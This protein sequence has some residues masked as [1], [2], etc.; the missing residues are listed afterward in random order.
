MRR[1]ALAS[2]VCVVAVA[3]GCLGR[4]GIGSDELDSIDEEDAA[5][6]DSGLALVDATPDTSSPPETSIEDTRRDTFIDI[7]EVFPIPD[8]GPIGVCA[9]CVRDM[10]GT[11]VNAC[12]NSP[13]CRSGLA[14]TVAKCLAGGGGGGPG[15]FDLKCVTDCFGGDLSKALQAVATFTCITGKCGMQCGG[16]LGGI[17]GFP[18]GGGGG[19]GAKYAFTPEELS[20]LPMSTTFKFSPEAFTPWRS[21][22]QKSA[23][24]QQLATCAP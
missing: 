12:I 1:L 23:C 11:Q 4:T 10:C 24:E 2:I 7:W 13:E 15:G 19:M 17:P 5:A 14:C 8:S 16:L 18:G 9:S 6:I 21:V 22:L 20:R 3:V